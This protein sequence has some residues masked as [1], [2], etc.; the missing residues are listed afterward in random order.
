M[1]RSPRPRSWCL[2]LAVGGVAMNAQYF[3]SVLPDQARFDL[4]SIVQFGLSS[5]LHNFGLP[6]RAALAIGSL[7]YAV[8]VALGIAW[9]GK[10]KQQSLAM[11]VLVPIAFAVTGGVYIHLTQL[12]AVLPVSVCRGEPN[13]PLITWAGVSL[14]TVPWNLLNALAPTALTVPHV[15]EVAA[16]SVAGAALPGETA[17][18]ANFLAYVGIA[19]VLCTLLAKS[20]LWQTA[21]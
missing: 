9:A 4:G 12:A 14:L 2:Q 20:R 5:M 3:G 1:W 17:Y 21:Q 7:Q 6:D 11:V 8:F 15:A 16:R 18:L 13:A 19:C 10:L